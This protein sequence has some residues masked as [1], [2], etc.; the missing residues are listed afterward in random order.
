[1]A[2]FQNLTQFAPLPNIG[3]PMKGVQPFTFPM[4]INPASVATGLSV[5][6]PLKLFPDTSTSE[7][8]VDLATLSTDKVFAIIPGNTKKNTYAA[9]DVV[10]G[11]AEGNTLMLEATA[12]INAGAFLVVGNTSAAGGGPGVTAT[13]T[14]GTQYGA[15]A[16]A[17]VSAGAT[18][19]L[20]QVKSGTV[21]TILTS[22]SGTVALT[23]GAATVANTAV[24][25]NSQ[26]LLTLKTLAGTFATAPFV[27]T[28]TPG[29][30]FTIAGGGGSNTSTLNYLIL[31]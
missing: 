8:V 6:T 2:L 16:L 17:S 3:Q 14:P 11:F 15:I 22:A 18:A 12:A 7:I 9:G 26:I 27:G 20:V 19:I 31:N 28:I 13:T 1:M 23:A 4:R 30:G 21:P 25:A 10:D 5:G 24:T 29:T